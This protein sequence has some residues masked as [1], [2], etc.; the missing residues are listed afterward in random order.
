MRYNFKRC[1]G[2]EWVS[3]IKRLYA[4]G[5][6]FLEL[7]PGEIYNRNNTTN[8]WNCYY[9][10]T[11]TGCKIVYYD[12]TEDGIKKRL[13]EISFTPKEINVLNCVLTFR[14][15]SNSFG[16]LVPYDNTPVFSNGV[17]TYFKKSYSGYVTVLDMNSAYLYVLQQPLADVTTRTEC[18]IQDLS[19]SDYDYFSFENDIHREMVYKLDYNKLYACAIWA[20][21]KIY[22]YK[23]KVHY[24]K[25]AQELYRLKKEVN[26][27]KYKNVANIAIGCM[28]K[29][30]GKQNNTTIAASLYAYFEWYIGDLVEKFEHKGYNVI[31]ITTDS[32]KVEGKYNIEDNIVKLGE[33]L[34]EFKLEYE[35]LA[36]YE[37]V[38]HYEEDQIKWKGKPKYLIDGYKPCKFIENLDEELEVYEKY[39]I[40]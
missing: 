6:T 33:G 37:S 32:I 2:T 29:K 22:G 14:K 38:G 23:G 20:D 4:R 21:V 15:I 10:R 5:T 19:G 30:S 28:H 25:T 24:E 40:E 13:R 7:G 17:Y 31:M 35:G 9:Y 39:A 1:S 3:T 34:G 18:S 26:K 12:L 16:E 11:T 8:I 27:M 36:K